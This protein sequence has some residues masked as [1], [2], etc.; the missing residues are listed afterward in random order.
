M[1]GADTKDNDRFKLPASSL[2]EIFKIVQGYTSV[3][4]LASLSDISK[5]TGMHETVVSRN[6]G[7]LLS[8]GVLEGG[9]KKTPTD[10][11][12]KLGLAL[13]HNVEE[14]LEAILSGIVSENDFLKNVLAA[15]RIRK[16]MDEIALRSHVAYSAGQSKTSG[17]ST[18][19]GAV[20]ELLKRSGHL[21]AE[22]GKLVIS[23]LSERAPVQET[24]VPQ[25]TL[26]NENA[27][28]VI[29]STVQHSP[30]AI[31][32]NIEVRCEPHELEGLGLKLKKIVNDFSNDEAHGLGED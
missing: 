30:F 17:T 28:G 20:V 21:R 25:I 29:P 8:I 32:I 19:T 12:K 31:T 5:S 10:A 4:K 2:D 9:Q 16:G 1:A 23:T 22:D 6:V 3:G 15:V 18:G 26:K 11:G 7:F 14:E 27:R 13:M 24:Q